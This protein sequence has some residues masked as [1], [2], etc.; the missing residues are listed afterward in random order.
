ML[1]LYLY[2]INLELRKMKDGARKDVDWYGLFAAAIFITAS[3]Q[4]FIFPLVL[5]YQNLAP[6]DILYS[7]VIF[8]DDF[9]ESQNNFSLHFLFRKI[10]SLL[11]D[12]VIFSCMFNGLKNLLL[13]ALP[14][15]SFMMEFCFHFLGASGKRK[16]AL[17]YQRQCLYIKI[18]LEAVVAVN[19]SYLIAKNGI[20]ACLAL[21]FQAVP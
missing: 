15:A 11:F 21:A 17:N 16:F 3:L 19:A 2:L 14:T 9:T 13:C 1:K 7:F 5:L 20:G 6:L 10:I 8:R 4:M 18:Y 12:C